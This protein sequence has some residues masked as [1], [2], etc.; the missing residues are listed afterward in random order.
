[1]A[2]KV[3]RAEKDSP[4]AAK[5]LLNEARILARFSHPNV[6]SIYHAGELGDSFYYVMDYVEGETPRAGV[7]AT[8]PI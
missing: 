4:T 2:V 3:L 8:R 1:M 5:R 6:V 7:A